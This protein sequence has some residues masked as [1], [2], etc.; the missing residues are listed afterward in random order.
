MHVIYAVVAATG[1]AAGAAGLYT[2]T[3]LV[4]ALLSGV[5]GR[6]LL[7]FGA[8]ILVFAEGLVPTAIIAPEL[9]WL[10]G[11]LIVGSAFGGCRTLIRGAKK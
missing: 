4:K 2:L 6:A 5:A 11:F 10:A 9:L 7:L 8:Q 3:R 1:L